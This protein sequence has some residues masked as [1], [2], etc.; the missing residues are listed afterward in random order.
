MCWYITPDDIDKA[1]SIGVS[2]R[3][4]YQRVRDQGWSIEN[5][6]NTPVR[7]QRPR[8]TYNKFSAIAKEN[9]I[10]YKTMLERINELG[11]EPIRAA[12]QPIESSEQKSARM[13]VQAKKQK[14]FPKEYIQLAA[15]NGIGYHT[16]RMRVR[17]GK[18]YKEAATRP[19]RYVSKI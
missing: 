6:V 2:K 14:R 1:E 18:S 3:L 16:F 4:L 5:A 12:T 17:S 11:W 15:M 13:K 8:G 7:N 10:P 19:L 9:N